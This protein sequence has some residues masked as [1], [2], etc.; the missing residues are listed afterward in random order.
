MK[1]TKI[2]YSMMNM[3]KM[4]VFIEQ[5]TFQNSDYFKNMNN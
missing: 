2:F 5:K 3:K 1:N 4:D